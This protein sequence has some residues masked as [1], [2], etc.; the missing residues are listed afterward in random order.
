[1]ATA[2]LPVGEYTCR[3]FWSSK[4]HSVIRVWN[5]AGERVE[6]MDS[7]PE[8]WTIAREVCALLNAAHPAN[9]RP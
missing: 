7:T 1:M 4:D 9:P 8:G 6:D 5:P 2:A 3:Q